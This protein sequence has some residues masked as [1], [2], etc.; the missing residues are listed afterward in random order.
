MA[1]LDRIY[2]PK[3]K[4]DNFFPSFYTILGNSLGLDQAPI[5]IELKIGRDERSPT[6]FKWNALHLKDFNLIMKIKEK[7]LSLPHDMDFFGKLRHFAR[8]YKWFSKEKAMPFKTNELDIKREL[9]EASKALH[10]DIY[11]KDAQRA[12]NN[13]RDRLRHIEIQN[14]K[15]AAIRA[16][17]K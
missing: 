8:F 15:G 4:K 7:W 10:L 5:K 16:R 2:T 1:R 6:T 12:V 3:N 14:A 11:N 17:A 13:L 9:E